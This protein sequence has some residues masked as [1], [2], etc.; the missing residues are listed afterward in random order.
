MLVGSCRM[1]FLSRLRYIVVTIDTCCPEPFAELVTIFAIIGGGQVLI[2]VMR[3]DWGLHS[4]NDLRGQD[5]DPQQTA[6]QFCGYG[7]CILWVSDNVSLSPI[8]FGD[9]TRG[10]LFWGC[11]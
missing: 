10:M 7:H 4:G 5:A 9:V 11:P 2:S 1:L 6:L 8:S 3:W